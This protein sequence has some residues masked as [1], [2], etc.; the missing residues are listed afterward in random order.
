MNASM[1]EGVV[2][3][4]AYVMEIVVY[5]HL[6]RGVIST[7]ML[8]SSVRSRKR[9]ALEILEGKDKIGVDDLFG[10]ITGV[11]NLLGTWHS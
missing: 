9:N 10:A 1:M 7:V 8:N 4:A 2:A 5:L 6:V 11:F 3:V